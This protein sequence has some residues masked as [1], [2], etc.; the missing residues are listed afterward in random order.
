VGSFRDFIEASAAS[1]GRKLISL[2]KY[3]TYGHEPPAIGTNYLWVWQDGA[4]D[5]RPL[6]Y[7]PLQRK[8]LHYDFWGD[9]VIDLFRGRY[10]ATH[11]AV[12]VWPPYRI[13]RI[14]SI[15]EKKLIDQFGTTNIILA[16]P[17]RM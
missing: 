12:T 9:D 8:K 14:P 7:G 5:A 16:D 15:L 11:H 3:A 1:R 6:G 13:A 4:I 2:D 17:N 10:D